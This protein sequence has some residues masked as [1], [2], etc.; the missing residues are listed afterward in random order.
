MPLP[1]VLQ[2]IQAFVFD[3][4]G[5]LYQGD[6][7]L[8][9]AAETVQAL[10]AA[11][12]AVCFAT[13]TTT[14]SRRQLVEKLQ[15][16]GFDAS[17][18]QVF[19]PPA[20]AGTFLREQGAS[21]YLLVPEAAYEDFAGVRRDD[22]N[23]DFVVVGD[24]GPA[25]TFERLNQAFRLIQERGAR[26]IGLGRT[27]YWQTDTGLQLDAGPF[28]AALEYATGRPALIF[29]KPDR[30]FF[31]QICTLL[32]LSP[33]YVAMV[34][35][36]IRTDVEAAMQAGLRGVLVRTGKFRPSDLDGSV[37]PDLVIDTVAALHP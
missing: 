33:A 29:G 13:N 11:G 31:A 12:Y 18:A 22:V 27:R 30:R 26:L 36:D 10:Q 17:P 32:N 37:Q 35:D 23:P 19:S 1:D 28:I 2:H 7:A 4:D 8:P 3:L 16:L 5:T 14:R 21:A 24:L 6:R 34:G 20:L 25:W 15:R 9:G